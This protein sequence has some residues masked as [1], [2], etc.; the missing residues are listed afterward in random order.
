MPPFRFLV[1]VARVDRPLRCFA[2]T[3]MGQA[4]GSFPKAPVGATAPV[5]F[6]ITNNNTASNNGIN[7]ESGA[8]HVTIGGDQRSRTS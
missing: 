2:D 1:Q 6:T 5:T 3:A 8:V 4:D 7:L